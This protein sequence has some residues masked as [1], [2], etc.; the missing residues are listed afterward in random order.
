MFT[1]IDLSE[2]YFMRIEKTSM[3][4]KRGGKFVQL[5]NSDGEYLVFSPKELSSFH[6]NIVERFCMM[7]KIKGR[8]T[9]KRMDCFEIEDQEWE[10]VGGGKWHID[11]KEKKLVLFDTSGMYGKFES[12]GLKERIR[13][14][15]NMAEYQIQIL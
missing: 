1:I 3:P 13:A 10:I 7:Q 5:R 2:V 14:S 11:T 15:G 8:Y 6:A 12:K 9:S 4:D